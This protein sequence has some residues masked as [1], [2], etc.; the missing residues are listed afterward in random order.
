[1]QADADDFHLKFQSL[2]SIDITRI[3]LFNTSDQA[4]TAKNT[5]QAPETNLPQIR[6]KLVPV[7][8]QNDHSQGSQNLHRLSISAPRFSLF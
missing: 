5:E 1:M 6:L 4:P 2:L 3:K 8:Y 7:H